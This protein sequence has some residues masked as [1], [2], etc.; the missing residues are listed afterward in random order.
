[1]MG[2]HMEMEYHQVEK[3]E[4]GGRATRPRGAGAEGLMEAGEVFSALPWLTPSCRLVLAPDPFAPCPLS[5]LRL[6]LEL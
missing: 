3:A 2:I 5:C 1:M 6:S 4:E